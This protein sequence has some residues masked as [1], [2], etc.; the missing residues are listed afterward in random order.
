MAARARAAILLAALAAGTVESPVLAAS[1]PA[2][3][4]QAAIRGIDVS[5][6]SG[7]RL[8]SRQGC[9]FAVP[10]SWRP[11]DEGATAPDG[12]NI[13]V[14]LFRVASWPAH[15][16]KIKAAFGRVNVMHED[17]DHRLWFEIGDKPRVQH[18]VDVPN[19]VSVCSALLEIRT[20]T[21]P[22]AEGTAKKIV[23]SVGPWEQK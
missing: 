12:S 13:S 18:Y 4:P 9:Q 21:T 8:V 10:V 16:A 23:E 3:K 22:D 20:S 6:K 11:D 19:G 1:R 14:R 2:R 5:L 15:K 17:S 7:W